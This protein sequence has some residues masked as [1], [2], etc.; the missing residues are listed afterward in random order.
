[1]NK[2]KALESNKKKEGNQL[3]IAN[4]LIFNPSDNLQIPTKLQK[5]RKSQRKV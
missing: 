2:N 1:M 3:S 5:K 4:S